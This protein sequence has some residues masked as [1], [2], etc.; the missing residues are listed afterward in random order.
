[1]GDGTTGERADGFGVNLPTLTGAWLAGSPSRIPVGK[2]D[3]GFTLIEDSQASIQELVHI[4]PG[5]RQ[6][7]LWDGHSSCGRAQ[8]GFAVCGHQKR[9]YCRY[10]PPAYA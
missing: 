10:P 9:W 2:G 8:G 1:M 5:V 6:G 3:Q 7:S 4:D